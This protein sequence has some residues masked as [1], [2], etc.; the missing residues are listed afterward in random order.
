MNTFGSSLKVRTRSR[1]PRRLCLAALL[2]VSVSAGGVASAAAPTGGP[3]PSSSVPTYVHKLQPDIIATMQR[4]RMPGAIVAIRTPQSGTWVTRLG[5]AKLTTGA[6]LRLGDHMRIGSITKTFTATVILQLAQGRR[7]SLQSPVSRYISG[8]PNGRHITIHQLLQMTSGL[9]NYSEA[10]SFNQE[11]DRNP[12]RH[13]TPWELLHIAFAH[14][15]YFAPGK[16]YHYSNT[17][18]ILLGLIVQ[19][20][21]HHTLTYEFRRR[22]FRPLGM[23]DTSLPATP[24]MP[25]PY[26]HGYQ[27]ISNVDSLTSPPLTGKAAAWAD[28]SAGNPWD[29]TNASPS[30]T[31]AAGGAVSTVKDL[32]RYGPALA[33][34]HGLLGAG[35][36]RKRLEF[37]ATTTGTN[38]LGYGLGIANF[39]GFLGHTGSIPGYNSFVAYDPK[40]HATV[41]VLVNLNQ[42]PDANGPADALDKL[43]I[44]QVFHI[45]P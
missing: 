26:A 24:A 13:W 15:P 35:M 16:G 43:I 3:S 17:N 2:L 27:F 4:M 37:V 31:W 6:A 14:S 38:K 19:K 36:Q 20:L 41:V 7:L 34:G 40:L 22:I 44:G 29:V 18:Y 11:L 32:L 23:T 10:L 21:T 45:H 1:Y 42:S 30:W 25:L 28:W 5:S 8:V 12:A 9:Y 39:F 33:T